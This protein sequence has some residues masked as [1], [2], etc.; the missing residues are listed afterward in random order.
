MSLPQQ[1]FR[2][3]VFQILYSKDMGQ[4]GEDSIV[5][6]LSKELSVSKKSVKEALDKVNRIFEK[7]PEIDHIIGNTS[8]SYR[9]ERIRSIERNV[10]RLGVF[11]IL[12]DDSIPPKVA[13]SEAI[14]LSKKF[15]TPEATAFVNAL[16]DVIYKTSQ[17]EKVNI[18]TLAETADQLHKSEEIS[19]EV[20]HQDSLQLENEDSIP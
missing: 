20:L 11:E 16:L 14:R 10:L 8:E 5:Q 19:S 15:G 12:Y 2:E 17:G 4:T 1:K 18:D 6:L 9:F 13:I 7:L 3:I